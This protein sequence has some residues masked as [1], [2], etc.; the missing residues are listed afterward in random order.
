MTTSTDRKAAP[1]PVGRRVARLERLASTDPQAAQDAA[2]GWFDRLGRQLPSPAAQAE[3]ADLFAAG[4][5]AS[6]VD[7]Q[8]QGLV[9]GW[10]P[11]HPA[12][13]AGGKALHAA[14]TVTGR[15][16]ALPWLG[17]RFDT[18]AKRGT[19]SL[20]RLGL[21][22]RPLT[23]VQK[24]GDHYEAF[25]MTN[26]VEPGKIDPD[27]DVLVIDYAS[28]PANPWPV[29]RIRDE[30]VEIVPDTY[31]GKMLWHQGDDY[32]LLAYFALKTPVDS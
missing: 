13:N 17:K 24:A 4:A 32:Y 1:S 7:G 14:A 20:D 5:P 31:L 15:L 27:T 22:V 28:V 26:W 6:S 21:M 16:G 30:L 10:L 18:D 11:R 25:P 12:L 2:W 29:S 8:T 3:L 9:V 19:N 23:P